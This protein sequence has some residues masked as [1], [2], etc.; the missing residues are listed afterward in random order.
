M[1]NVDTAIEQVRS[2]NRFHTRLVG[3]L[4]EGLLASDFPLVQVRILYELAHNADV[5]AADLMASLSV[6]RGYLSRMLA[7][8][9]ERG[10]INKTPD[11]KN[12]KRMVLSLSEEGATV[13][14]KLNQASSDEVGELLASLS[15]YE[16]TELVAAMSKVRRLLGDKSQPR[17]YTLRDPVPGDMGWITHRQG[18]LYWNEYQ[19]DWRFEALVSTIVGEFAQNFD[20]ESERCWVAEMNNEIVGSV[21]VVR[22]DETTAK[23]RLLYVEEAA[24][25]LGLG[26]ALVDEVVQF[27][28]AKGYKKLVLWTNSVLGSARHIYEDVGFELIDEAPHHSFGH[29]LVGQTWSLDL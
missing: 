6:D 19:W 12:K 20:A 16:R 18:L 2:F 27:S 28:R 29:D 25:G 14:A 4:D 10:L 8:L 7:S 11:L 21:F 3:A 17:N 22:H 23:L 13:F 26:R 24:R 5:A 9:S 15:E 1:Q